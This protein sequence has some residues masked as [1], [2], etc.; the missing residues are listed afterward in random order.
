[1]N[2]YIFVNSRSYDF[3]DKVV[4]SPTISSYRLLN[5]IYPIY[6]GTRLQSFLKP[7]DKFIFYLAGKLKSKTNM[8]VAH[9]EIEDIVVNNFYSEDDLHISSPIGKVIKLKSIVEGKNLSIYDV[10]DNLSFVT[11]K[12]KWGSSMQGGIIQITEKD[13]NLITKEMNK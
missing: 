6:D 10:K 8:F 1:M 2:F 12:K 4:G 9:G 13:Y 3:N 11:K 5:K 7:N